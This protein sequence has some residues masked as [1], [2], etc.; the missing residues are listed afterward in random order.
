MISI[1]EIKQELDNMDMA[2]PDMDALTS[3]TDRL[4][5]L[6]RELNGIIVALDDIRLSQSHHLIIKQHLRE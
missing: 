4:E 6:D 1:D 3:L 2:N 5:Q